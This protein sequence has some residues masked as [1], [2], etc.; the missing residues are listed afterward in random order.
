MGVKLPLVVKQRQ[1]QPE[2][3]SFT[4]MQLRGS[5]RFGGEENKS[6]GQNSGLYVER[7]SSG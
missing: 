7:V 2:A 5:Y 4:L 6:G 1:S 3:Q